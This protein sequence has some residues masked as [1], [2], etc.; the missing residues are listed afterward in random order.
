MVLS[1]LQAAL[2]AGQFASQLDRAIRTASHCEPMSTADPFGLEQ[3]SFE[4]PA[5]AVQQVEHALFS[6]ALGVT[7]SKDVLAQGRKLTL[8]TN[9]P[10]DVKAAQTF[11][12]AHRPERYGHIEP[13]KAAPV[14]IAITVQFVSA[15]GARLDAIDVTSEPAL[16]EQDPA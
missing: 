8:Q 2:F 11:L 4:L 1:A 10:G 6:R 12:A 5:N 15:Q 13:V 3:D 14:P 16:I 9:V 7:I